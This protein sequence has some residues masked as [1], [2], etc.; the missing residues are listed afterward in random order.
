MLIRWAVKKDIPVWE[1]LS[2]EYDPYISEI[3]GDLSKWYQGFNDY[4]NRKIEQYEAVIAVDRM[5]GHCNGTIAFSRSHNR[6]TFFAVSPKNRRKETAESL[7]KVAL[8]QLNT[9]NDITVNVPK[10]NEGLLE[11]DQRFF[12]ENG[13]H[14][15]QDMFLDGCP[16]CELL[17]NADDNKCGGSFHY[18][19]S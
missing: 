14:F 6:I 9:N 5:S 2:K 12:E 8:R 15:V 10:S 13:F 16:M 4:M 3:S 18:K 1:A 7:L 19:Y 17:R 11:E